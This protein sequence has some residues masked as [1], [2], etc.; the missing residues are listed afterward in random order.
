M[1][2]TKIINCKRCGM[3]WSWC[4]LREY[5]CIFL[6]EGQKSVW[7]LGK[8]SVLLGWGAAS[9]GVWFSKW[10]W[11]ASTNHPMMQYHYQMNGDLSCTVKK[12][13]KYANIEHSVSRP[14]LASQTA[15]QERNTLW[16]VFGVSSINGGCW[17]VI[18]RMVK[19][20]L[21]QKYGF[22]VTF[23]SIE[24]LGNKI[25]YSRPNGC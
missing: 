18:C 24:Y 16:P 7:T 3:K 4:N 21:R 9:L 2:I 14:G 15:L 5:S 17:F 20:S 11:M 23:L 13:L 8:V 1:I 22:H 25:Y 6:K 19:G 10:P 12:A